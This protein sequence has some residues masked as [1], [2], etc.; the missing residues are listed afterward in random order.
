[1]LEI[2]ISYGQ[3]DQAD[4][5]VGRRYCTVCPGEP[6]DDTNPTDQKDLSNLVYTEKKRGAIPDALAQ[7]IFRNTV[8]L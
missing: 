1:M 4:V 2:L 7:T 6:M 8:T 5:D 3:A